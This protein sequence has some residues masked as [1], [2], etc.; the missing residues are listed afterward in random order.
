MG[1]LEEVSQNS[2]KKQEPQK[3]TGMLVHCC[4]KGFKRKGTLLL[5]GVTRI[6]VNREHS[7]VP[8]FGVS[9]R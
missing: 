1:L 3:K 7:G 9:E 8:F 5:S 4:Y 2:L 6:D